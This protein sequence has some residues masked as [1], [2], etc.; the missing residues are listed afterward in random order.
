M[1]NDN[2]RNKRIKFNRNH[3][4]AMSW[5][6]VVSKIYSRRLLPEIYLAKNLWYEN[7]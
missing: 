1:E 4:F 3:R 2:I 5:R 6:Y 7:F